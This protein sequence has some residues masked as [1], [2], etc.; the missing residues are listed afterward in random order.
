MTCEKNK[1][2]NQKVKKMRVKPHLH[3]KA[4]AR[5]LKN[6]KEKMSSTVYASSL[7]FAV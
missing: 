7:F 2:Q 1:E 4:G 3:F 6:G 5:T